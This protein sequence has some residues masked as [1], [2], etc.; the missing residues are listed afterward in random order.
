MTAWGANLEAL[1]TYSI[2]WI[3]ELQSNAAADIA[4]TQ[5]G[6]SDETATSF[7]LGDREIFEDR[8]DFN[9]ASI[10]TGAFFNHFVPKGNLEGWKKNA[11]FFGKAGMELYQMVV[12]AGL[13]S[14]LMYNSPQSGALLHMHSKDSGLGKTT[15]MFMAMTPWGNPKGLLLI[16]PLTL[17]SMR[18]VPWKEIS[19]CT[20]VSAPIMVVIPLSFFSF[21]ISPSRPRFAGVDGHFLLAIG[22]RPQA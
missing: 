8:I 2:R 1:M 11:A 12:C 22:R 13:G 6:W 10:K 7:I 15:A 14:A 17:P 21:L 18:T 4:H 5:F 20:C 19:P 3:E 9:P 16:F